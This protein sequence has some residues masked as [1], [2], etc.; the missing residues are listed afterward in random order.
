MTVTRAANLQVMFGYMFVGV[1]VK[2]GV[3]ESVSVKAV[4]RN[5]EK[6]KEK[7]KRMC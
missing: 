6:K 4:K 5:E 7:E 1:R 3:F 2:R